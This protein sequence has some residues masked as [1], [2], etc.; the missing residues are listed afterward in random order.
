MGGMVTVVGV[1]TNDIALKVLENT[2][3]MGGSY[4]S[5]YKYWVDIDILQICEKYLLC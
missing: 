1:I 2:D 3:V 4:R 5:I